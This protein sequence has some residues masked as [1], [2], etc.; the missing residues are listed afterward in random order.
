M[1]RADD[2]PTICHHGMVADPINAFVDDARRFCSLVEQ[3]A[4]SSS[5]AF[6]QD[7][8]S[9]VMSLY[10]SALMLPEV[11]ADN[12]DLLAR[13]DHEN[14]NVLRQKIALKL[15]RDFYWMVFEPLDRDS[16]AP[17]MGS[18]SDDLADIWRDL[19]PGLLAMDALSGH[20]LNDVVCGWRSSFEFHWGH[21]VAS[22]VPAL[23]ALCFG[24]H[25]DSTRCP[26]KP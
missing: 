2:G 7:C 9:H 3:D 22:A 1:R 20:T 21:H 16:P 24:D 25:A 6:A 14:W 12:P 26:A 17:V 10:G 8:L 15:S 18:L 4:V 5:W 19:K 13:I 23:H 11:E